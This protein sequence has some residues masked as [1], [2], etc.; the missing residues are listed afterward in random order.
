ME[1]C[2]RLSPRFIHICLE[3]KRFTKKG[4]S[5]NE[6]KKKKKIAMHT[7]PPSTIVETGA[8]NSEAEERTQALN[9]DDKRP[10]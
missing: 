2:V 4:T 7:Y 8:K 1:E 9:W 6:K 3:V 10:R 5:C